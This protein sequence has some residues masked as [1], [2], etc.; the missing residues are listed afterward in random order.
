MLLNAR[1]R[2]C[3]VHDARPRTHR[4]TDRLLNARKRRCRVHYPPSR[5]QVAVGACSTLESVVVGFTS[6]SSAPLKH[7]PPAQRS[8]ASLSGSQ[9]RPI[10][11]RPASVLL[12]ARKRRCRVHILRVGL[13]AAVVP[14]QRSK[15]SL[16]GSPSG[17]FW[18]TRLTRLLNARKRRCRVHGGTDRDHRHAGICSTLESVVVGFTS[19]ITVGP[20]ALRAAQRSKASLSGSRP[21]HSTFR[22]KPTPAQRSKASL[23]GSR[24]SGERLEDLRDLLNARK[25]RCRVHDGYRQ[26]RRRRRSICSTLESVVVGFTSRSA[27]AGRTWK[28]LNARKRRCRVHGDTSGGF[29]RLV[30]LLNARKRRCRVHLQSPG[31]GSCGRPLL[32]ARKRRCRVHELGEHA[33]EARPE[34]LNARKRRCRV[35]W[36]GVRRERGGKLLLNARKRRC[37]V[38]ANTAASP[39]RFDAAQRSKASLSGSRSSVWS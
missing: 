39:S 15:A 37:R 32:N 5:V 1:K 17:S 13:L 26:H 4:R 18:M 8:K 19:A 10:R 2:R 16:S 29:S 3:R 22:P 34:L 9:I 7:E 12:N 28:L 20:T 38:H 35:H 33:L 23:S 21:P 36:A 6:T 31:R 11:E 30:I 25:R 24:R 14:A 27:P